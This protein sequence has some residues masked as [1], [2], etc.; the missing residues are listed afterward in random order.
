[1]SHR[2]KTIFLILVVLAGLAA[3]WWLSQEQGN[4]SRHLLLS[5]NIELRTV[6]LG[7]KVPGRIIELNVEEGDS[8]TKGTVIARLEADELLRQRDQSLAALVVSQS[9]IKELQ[10]ALEFQ[11]ESVEAQIEQRRAERDQ[12]GLLLE[13]L[14]SGSREQEIDEARAAL[15]RSQA[16]A[17]RAHSDWERAQTLYRNQDISTAQHDQFRSV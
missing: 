14:L 5:G 1:M 16:E 10:A 4:G 11:T 6:H 9:R 2:K 15:R 17:D 8:I 7:F 13:Q 3:L 12:A